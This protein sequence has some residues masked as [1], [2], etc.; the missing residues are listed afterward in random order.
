MEMNDF[1]KGKKIYYS[2]ELRPGKLYLFGSNS[3]NQRLGRFI[4]WQITREYLF[5]NNN[6]MD[7]VFLTDAGLI[8]MSCFNDVYEAVTKKTAPTP[9]TS[10]SGV[11]I[12][13]ENRD[14]KY[15]HLDDIPSLNAI[16]D[17][18]T[19][20]S[21]A[22]IIVRTDEKPHLYL[23]TACSYG[24]PHNWTANINKAAIL[25]DMKAAEKCI[26]ELEDAPVGKSLLK[27]LE[28]KRTTIITGEPVKTQR[29]SRNVKE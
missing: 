14:A 8:R 19:L 15:D 28:I 29:H 18:N 12:E 10:A 1:T 4:G 21:K 13:F 2:T 22:F 16:S 7:S 6:E 11:S 27:I 26:K 23:Y 20:S 25:P 9:L 3:T 24:G 17:T 5:D